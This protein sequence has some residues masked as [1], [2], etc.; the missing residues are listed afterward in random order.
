MFPKMGTEYLNLNNQVLQVVTSF[1]PTADLFRACWWPPFWGNEKVTL[2]KLERDRLWGFLGLLDSP[3]S[4][5]W[6]LCRFLGGLFLGKLQSVFFEQEKNRPAHPKSF[7]KSFPYFF[8]T[9][10]LYW[11]FRNAEKNPPLWDIYQKETRSGKIMGWNL[12]T[13]T[14]KKKYQ[15]SEPAQVVSN[16]AFLH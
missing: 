14:A 12:T 6:A 10:R 15:I 1:G 13:P 5:I 7:S 8:V 16:S 4:S 11:W 2:K 3:S 9:T